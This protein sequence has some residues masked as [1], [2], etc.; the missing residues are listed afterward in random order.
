M[1]DS[2]SEFVKRPRAKKPKRLAD[3]E[4][5]IDGEVIEEVE[6]PPKKAPRKAK[7]PQAPK[8][9]AEPARKR[10]PR[11]KQP[12][13]LEQAA[14][15]SPLKG[16]LPLVEKPKMKV[17]VGQAAKEAKLEHAS[18][19]LNFWGL[20]IRLLPMWALI[21]MVLMIAP[22]LPIDIA[23]GIIGWVQGQFPER[24]VYE[25][26]EP[27]YVVEDTNGMLPQTELPPPNWSL[28]VSPIFTPEV[29]YWKDRIAEWSM[30][31][32]IKPNMIATIMQIESC[33]NPQALSGAEA[34]G[35]FQVMPLHFNNSEDPFDPDT[36]AGR[37]LLFLGEMLA[38]ANGDSGLAFAA[39]NG[40]P[41]MLYISP[42]EWPEETQNYQFWASGIYE[43]AELALGASPTLADWLDAGG[44]SL[45]ADAANILSLTNP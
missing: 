13:P 38:S 24:P 23:K 32:R 39:Y 2:D 9:E 42:G 45:C 17:K 31:Y 28:D 19:P 36:N 11:S 40:G 14:A 34:R 41:S 15:R 3:E 7:Q 44:Y 16:W 21:V 27:V 37:G 22:S 25:P 30:A 5:F 10:A 20:M 12:Q 43:E 26:G 35:L 29:L 8:R 18:R 6:T 4:S 1:S 33:G